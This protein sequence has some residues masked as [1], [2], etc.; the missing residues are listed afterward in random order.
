MKKTIK[1]FK[2]SESFPKCEKKLVLMQ[3]PINHETSRLP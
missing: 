2:V 3:N 1:Y